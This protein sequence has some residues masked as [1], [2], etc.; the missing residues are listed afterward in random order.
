MG[1]RMA[2]GARPADVLGRVPRQGGR[3]VVVGIGAGALLAARLGRVLGS[4]VYGVSALDPLAYAVAATIL[5]AVAAL[6]SFVP[7]LTAAR[8]DPLRAL[9][10]E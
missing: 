6:A 7:A 10:S 9:P 2:L 4:L 8:V 1:V 3:L 5:L